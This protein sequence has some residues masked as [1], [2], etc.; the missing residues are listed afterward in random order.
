MVTYC[1]VTQP[2]ISYMVAEA[3]QQGEGG[4]STPL[5][6]EPLKI[7]TS[8]LPHSEAK[9]S[10]NPAQISEMGKYPLNSCREELQSNVPPFLNFPQLPSAHSMRFK[11]PSVYGS[12]PSL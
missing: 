10:Y 11:F 3:S 8:F 7:N 5:E 2:V 12:A 9:A 4:S 1:L 6:V